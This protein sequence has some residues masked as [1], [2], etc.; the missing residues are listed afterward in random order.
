MIWLWS[1]KAKLKKKKLATHSDMHCNAN[2]MTTSESNVKS[3]QPNY[4][5][6]R[7]TLREAIR[8]LF[9]KIN[10]VYK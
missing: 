9:F 6:V 8:W 5:S 10:E 3:E 1:E 2:N 7:Q 4:D